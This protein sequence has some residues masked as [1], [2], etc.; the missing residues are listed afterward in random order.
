[1]KTRLLTSKEIKERLQ[2]INS[3]QFQRLL[4]DLRKYGAFKLPGSS[5]RMY[6]EDYMR[7]IADKQQEAQKL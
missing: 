3:M 6:E 2:L 7:Y 5:W 4:P 1:M